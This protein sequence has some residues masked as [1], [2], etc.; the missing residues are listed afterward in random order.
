[1]FINNRAANTSLL[2]SYFII[3]IDRNVK[4]MILLSTIIILQEN[5]HSLG[6]NHICVCLCEYYIYIYKWIKKVR[7][8]GKEWISKKWLI[9]LYCTGFFKTILMIE[10]PNTQV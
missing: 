7:M 4:K 6:H 9:F 10:S 5:N 1:M 8:E 3:R 2:Y